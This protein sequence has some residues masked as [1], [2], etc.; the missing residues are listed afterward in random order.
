MGE[1]RRVVGLEDLEGGVEGAESNHVSLRVASHAVR[2]GV[3]RSRKER[4]R[5][6]RLGC[7]RSGQ[8]RIGVGKWATGRGEAVLW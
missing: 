7:K 1:G 6:R 3:A 5:R 2:E 8:F 4:M